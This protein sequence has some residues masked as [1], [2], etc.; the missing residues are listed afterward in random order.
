MEPLT[1]QRVDDDIKKYGLDAVKKSV[2]KM[3]Q[4]VAP[5]Y[6]S[7]IRNYELSLASERREAR[8]KITLSIS[9]KARRNS[10][11]ATIIAISAIILNIITYIWPPN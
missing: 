3:S 8:E 7:L 2:S 9:R 6:D 5:L 11:W 1:Q 10:N 4:T